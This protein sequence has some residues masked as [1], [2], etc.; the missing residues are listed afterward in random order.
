MKQM[1]CYDMGFLDEIQ[2]I[3]KYLPQE[4]TDSNVLCYHAQQIKDL[5]CR[6]FRIIP[7]DNYKLTIQERTR[8][9][10]WTQLIVCWYLKSRERWCT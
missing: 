5:R 6:D 7:C 4:E 2:E 8:P 9:R 3:F 10:T 1:R